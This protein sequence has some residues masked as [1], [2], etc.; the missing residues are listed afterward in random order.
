MD[1]PK[2]STTLLFEYQEFIAGAL[3]TG[4]SFYE[5]NQLKK[6]PVNAETTISS[7]GAKLEE[8][9]TLYAGQAFLHAKLNI[10]QLIGRSIIL[11]KIKDQVAP[12]SLCGVIARSAEFGK[13]INKYAAVVARQYGRKE[14][15]PELKG[16]MYKD[17]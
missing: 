9:S 17:K 4:P 5:L 14:S 15:T 7:R 16:Y 1:Y 6:T 8:D 13:T 12:D 3:S 10:N 11:S 2:V